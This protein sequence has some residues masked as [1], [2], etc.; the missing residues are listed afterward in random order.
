MRFFG[1]GMGLI[2]NSF[3]LFYA[4]VGINLSRPQATMPQQLLN[5]ADIHPA[6]H[7]MRG[8]SMSQHVGATLALYPGFPQ[9]T[10]N[11]PV[12]FATADLLPLAC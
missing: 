10:M 3:Q 7:Q 6:V 11:D 4:V 12:D 1:P 2:V 8:E 9:N 5:G